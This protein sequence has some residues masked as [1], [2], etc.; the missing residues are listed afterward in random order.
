MKHSE[1]NQE[2]TDG[3]SQRRLSLA[4]LRQVPSISSD[5]VS[6]GATL[7][8]V[9]GFLDAYTFVT[10]DGIF[11]NAQ[12]G[13]VVL[14]GVEAALGQWS[15]AL[16]HLPPILAFMLGVAVAET[17]K[18][19]A[20]QSVLREPARAVLLVEIAVLL[21]VGLLPRHVPDMFVTVAISFVASIQVSA[22][23]RLIKWPYSSTMTT[24]NLRTATQAAYQAWIARDREAAERFLR[25]ATIIASFLAGAFTGTFSSLY[26]GNRAI[27]VAAGILLLTLLLYNRELAENAPAG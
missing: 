25:F 24:G 12:T 27:W 2:K 21:I 19:P 16:L 18:R 20:L 8:V 23:S 13:N 9:G 10:R 15:Q 6:L 17:L 4:R 5:S 14:F 3:I 11:A 1:P 26:L 7:A 22:F